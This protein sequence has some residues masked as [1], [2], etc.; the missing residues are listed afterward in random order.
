MFF[1]DKITFT[2]LCLKFEA[3]RLT[4]LAAPESQN[5]GA[6]PNNF[7]AESRISRERKGYCQSDRKRETGRRRRRK[8]VLFCHNN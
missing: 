7:K 4:N 8:E 2:K 6:I 3:H 5:F 1:D